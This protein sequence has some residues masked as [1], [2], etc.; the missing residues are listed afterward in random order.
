MFHQATPT[1]SYWLALWLWGIVKRERYNTLSI[2][3]FELCSV[4]SPVDDARLAYVLHSRTALFHET[5]IAPVSPIHPGY[6]QELST[7]LPATGYPNPHT[8]SYR[9]RP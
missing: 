4:S 8:P 6:P 2:S 5:S 7:T 1:P 3:A 9:I